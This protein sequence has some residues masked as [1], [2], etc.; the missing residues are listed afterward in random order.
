MGSY[1][2]KENLLL[3]GNFSFNSL[4][5]IFGGGGALAESR[6]NGRRKPEGLVNPFGMEVPPAAKL[7]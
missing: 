5:K 2:Y 1:Y 6:P 7:G 4:Y 3:I